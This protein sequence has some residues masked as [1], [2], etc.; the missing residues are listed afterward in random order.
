[1]LKYSQGNLNRR[2]KMEKVGLV[3][4]GGGF[5]GLYTSG[6][7]DCMMEE[8][9]Y[10]PYVVGVSMGAINACN[11]LSKQKERNYRIILDYFD[12]HRYCSKRNWLKTGNY[13]GMDF[14]FETIAKKLDPF[15]FDTFYNSEQIFESVVTDCKTGEADYIEHNACD[16]MK[17]IEASASLPFI[18]RMVTYEGSQYLDGGLADALPIDR[19]FEMGMEK[20]VVILTRP[21]DYVKEKSGQ[22]KLTKA[23]YRRYPELVD[24]L[25]T[26]HERYNKDFQRILKLEEQ[27]KVMAYFPEE[28]LPV[29][30]IEKEKS[31]LIKTYETGYNDGKKKM[32]NLKEFMGVY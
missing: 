30:R 11:Y 23:V 10:F 16:Y 4:E 13:F 19:A 1:M 8:K 26:R 5:R 31:A 18:S 29:K 2:M 20:V 27:G 17:V 25:L 9:V 14:I 12:D 6:I 32:E 24:L 28:N 7:I 21:R 3:L 22:E 15:D